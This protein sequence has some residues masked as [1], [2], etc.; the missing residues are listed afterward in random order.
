[1]GL[2][3]EGGVF[4]GFPEPVGDRRFDLV[5]VHDPNGVSE[6]RFRGTVH[7]V[8]LGSLHLPAKEDA[9]FKE[10]SLG[11]HE[12]IAGMPREHDGLVGRVD[13][14]VAELDSRFADSFPCVPQV[15]GEPSGEGCFGR[16]PAIVFLPFLDKV[17]AM[18]AYP[19]RHASLWHR[20][21]RIHGRL[22]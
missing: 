17:L 11:A 18:V 8:H 3:G 20:H 4:I 1:M 13:P 5:A 16:S 9:E 12:E 21:R 19:S 6:F 22:R 10:I 14:L 7:A 15:V 2:V